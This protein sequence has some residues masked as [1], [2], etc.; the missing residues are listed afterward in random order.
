M[1]FM[2][3]ALTALVAALDSMSPTGN[4]NRVYGPRVYT[5]KNIGKHYG[6]RWKLI[7][8]SVTWLSGKRRAMIGHRLYPMAAK[9]RTY[10]YASDRQSRYAPNQKL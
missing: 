3:S 9:G 10:S 8:N 6:I 4:P 1:G 2:K 7:P 5:N